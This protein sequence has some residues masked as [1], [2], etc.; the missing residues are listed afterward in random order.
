[1]LS[2]EHLYEFAL[3]MAA[4]P[5]LK[6]S[7]QMKRFWFSSR[8]YSEVCNLLLNGDDSSQAVSNGYDWTGW[9][10]SI[11]QAFQNGV[12]LGFLAHPTVSYTMV[13]A[14]RRGV[15]ISSQLLAVIVPVF[16]KETATT[17]LREDYIG[18]PTLTNFGYMTSAN[19]CHHASHLAHYAQEQ[20]KYFWDCASIV[21]WGGG[22]GNMARI[23]RKMNPSL[24]Y[25]IIDL[26]ELLALQYVYLSSIEG[27]G[28]VQ[29]VQPGSGMSIV[30]G[31]LNLLTSRTAA[32][33]GN[34]LKCDGFI[35]TWA[36]TESPVDAQKFVIE[37]ELFGARNILLGSLIN[38]NNHMTG[39]VD[40]MGLSRLPI[41]V[42]RGV[43]PGHEYWFR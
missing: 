30:P 37:K 36:I 4:R 3:Q 16:G 43:G 1:M 33:M 10:A 24:T 20:K 39:F 31:K 9:A 6:D 8:Q 27:A 26:P 22:Y 23:I 2:W 17:L 15:R 28:N 14:R 12:P 18:L 34:D 38:D 7:G 5:Q 19:R 40:D 25:I 41:P 32:S 35:S 11:R 29:V 13:F 42:S 21:E